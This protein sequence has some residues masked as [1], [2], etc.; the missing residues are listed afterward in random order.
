MRLARIALIALMAITVISTVSC[1]LSTGKITT[2]DNTIAT[3]AGYIYVRNTPPEYYN[4]DNPHDN[5]PW[6]IVIDLQPT[7]IAQAN[8]V[9]QVDLYENKQFRATATVSWN[10]LELNVHDT[11][12]VE[13]PASQDEYD[14]YSGHDINDVFSVDV[15]E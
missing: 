10:Q 1:S 2:P 7:D 9:Y 15:H 8:I 4:P 5:G 13:F 6:F 14:T 11:H 3:V 12:R